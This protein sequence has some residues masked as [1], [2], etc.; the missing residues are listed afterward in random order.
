MVL[1]ANEPSRRVLPGVMPHFLVEQTGTDDLRGLYRALRAATALLARR[2][3]YA[4][5]AC[6]AR[7]RRSSGGNVPSG[8]TSRSN[9]LR[10]ASRAGRVR[11]L[12]SYV[13]LQEISAAMRRLMSLAMADHLPSATA[14]GLV[15]RLVSS[16]ASARLR[17]DARAGGETRRAARRGFMVTTRRWC[18]RA[19]APGSPGRHGL[20]GRVRV[21]G[22]TGWRVPFR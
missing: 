3:M 2:S 22:D 20:V 7:R 14:R 5:L 6:S 13:R 4:R 9:R 11:A 18:A 16:S 10:N 1:N 19:S 15:S 12:R 8:S 21:G 17:A